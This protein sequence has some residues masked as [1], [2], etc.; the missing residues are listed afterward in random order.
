MQ[1]PFCPRRTRRGTENFKTFFVRGGAGGTSKAL[2]V[3]GGHGGG[4]EL[5]YILFYKALALQSAV[6]A[7]V[8][9][10]ADLEAGGF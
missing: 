9:E 3:H 5:L 6:A 4:G 10:E 8:E 2:L 1:K 7:E